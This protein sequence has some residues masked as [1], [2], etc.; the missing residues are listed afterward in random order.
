MIKKETFGRFFT[1]HYS[2]LINGLL[3]NELFWGKKKSV[4]G[5]QR[6]SGT[7][8]P[9]RRNMQKLKATDEKNSE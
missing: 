6:A 5:T 3:S 7:A 4:L 9:N 2:V 1:Q 8:Q